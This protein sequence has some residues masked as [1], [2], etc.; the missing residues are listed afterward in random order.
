MQRVDQ[1]GRKTYALCTGDETKI[2]VRTVAQEIEG[3]PINS[4]RAEL[5][6]ILA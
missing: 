4:D 2:K 3:W 6:G 1:K 5:R